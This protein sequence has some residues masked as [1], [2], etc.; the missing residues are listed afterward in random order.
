MFDLNEAYKLAGWLRYRCG[1]RRFRDHIHACRRS[2]D[3][4]TAQHH[5][6]AA[7]GI[8]LR[9]HDVTP[10]EWRTWNTGSSPDALR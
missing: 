2:L 10:E 6:V 4:P 9:H 3:L 8:A 1:S 5:L 7:L